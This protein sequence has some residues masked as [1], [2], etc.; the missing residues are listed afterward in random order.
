MRRGGMVSVSTLNHIH[1]PFDCKAWK[2]TVS[3][4]SVIAIIIFARL[5]ALRGLYVSLMTHKSN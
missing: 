2:G 5:G 4:L 1:E 3:I